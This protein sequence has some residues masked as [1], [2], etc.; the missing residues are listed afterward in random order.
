MRYT[1]T[2]V[3]IW[4]CVCLCVAVSNWTSWQHLF[5]N[6]SCSIRHRDGLI[7]GK[8]L[9]KAISLLTL[10][11]M[12]Y[13]CNYALFFPTEISWGNLIVQ[14]VQVGKLHQGSA[15]ALSPVNSSRCPV[16]TSSLAIYQWASVSLSAIEKYKLFLGAWFMPQCPKHTQL[17]R[18]E[19]WL[20]QCNTELQYAL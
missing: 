11:L 19:L 1:N 14:Q 3:Y 4:V 7:R 17:F 8:I 16:R 15:R 20:D 13:S 12:H 9:I 6:Y 10:I 18:L 2:H 5:A